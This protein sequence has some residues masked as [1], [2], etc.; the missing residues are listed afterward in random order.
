MTRIY[1]EIIDFIARG[2]S[3]AKIAEF[4][5]S[6]A[7][8]ERVAELIHR[9]KRQELSEDEVSELNHYLELEHIMRLAKAR[10]RAHLSNE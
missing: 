8:R 1:E 2:A 3:P 5:P 7:T 10:A 6:Q 9:E 4:S